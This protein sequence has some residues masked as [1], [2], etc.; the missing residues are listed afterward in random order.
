[1]H[2]NSIRELL[3]PVV[4]TEAKS[5]DP[6]QTQHIREPRCFFFMQKKYLCIHRRPQ[7]HVPLFWVL[8]FLC[9]LEFKSKTFTLEK[10]ILLVQHMVCICTG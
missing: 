10:L 9:N 5:T 6:L 8:F 3:M 1:M 2:D 4:R 7:S